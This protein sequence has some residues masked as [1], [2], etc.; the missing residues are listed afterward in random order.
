MLDAWRG[1]KSDDRPGR[2]EIMQRILGAMQDEGRKIVEEGI[3]R[4][5]DDVDVV[6]VHGY[7]FPRHLGGPMFMANTRG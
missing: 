2:E 7:G 4:S 1:S 5:P 6:M 3:A